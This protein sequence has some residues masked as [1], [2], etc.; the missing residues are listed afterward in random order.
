MAFDED[1]DQWTAPFVMAAINTRNVH[2]SNW[3]MDQPYGADFVYDEMVLT[4]PGEAG[5]AAAK[6]VG[7]ANAAMGAEGGPKPGEGP[8]KAE[9]EAG[10]YD[11]LF[12]ALADDGRQVRAGVKGDKDPGYGSTSKMI[13]ETALCL[14]AAP[15]VAGGIW[16]PALRCGGSWWSGCRP[17]RG[18]RSRWV[19]NPLPWGEGGA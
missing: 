18:W 5:E 13:A 2:R 16:T 19:G 10:F 1:L 12:V 11:L 15:E 14:I 6:A 8:G 9:R 7:L 4:G 17:R 3:L